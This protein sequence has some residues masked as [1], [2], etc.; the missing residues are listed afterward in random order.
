MASDEELVLT[1]VSDC[2]AAVGLVDGPVVLPGDAQARA[3]FIFF[4]QTPAK[5]L[6]AGDCFF[7]P[8]GGRPLLFGCAVCSEVWESPNRIV[9]SDGRIVVRGSVAAVVVLAVATILVA[10]SSMSP[11]ASLS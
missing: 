4:E 5:F 10:A 2:V 11:R 1:G 9:A 7:L 6:G 8:A 3:R